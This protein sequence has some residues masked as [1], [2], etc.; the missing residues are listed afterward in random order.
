MIKSRYVEL[1]GVNVSPS[2]FPSE[3]RDVFDLACEWGLSDYEEIEVLAASKERH[4]LQDFLDRFFRK[5]DLISEFISEGVER[6]PVPDEVVI[7]DLAFQS[8]DVLFTFSGDFRPSVE[9]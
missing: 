2:D 5:Q 6:V 7:M 8:Y 9:E 1:P 3:L 4:E